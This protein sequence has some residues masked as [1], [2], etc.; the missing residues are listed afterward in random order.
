MK[1]INGSLLK[2]YQEFDTDV[3]P[4]FSGIHIPTDVYD[5]SK[6]LQTVCT[7]ASECGNV[8]LTVLTKI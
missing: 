4:G 7:M 8:L 1:T 3:N 2:Y 5:E 6:L